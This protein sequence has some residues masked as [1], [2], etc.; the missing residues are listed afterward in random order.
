MKSLISL[1]LILSSFNTFAICMYPEDA[2]LYECLPMENASATKWCQA[3]YGEEFDAFLTNNTCSKKLAY[4]L[5]D[6]EYKETKRDKVG[7]VKAACLSFEQGQ[8]LNCEYYDYNLAQNFCGEKFGM[9][10][11]AF[12]PSSK[13]SLEVASKLRGEV[14]S[15]NLLNNLNSSVDELETLITMIDQEGAMASLENIGNKEVLIGNEFYTKTMTKILSYMKMTKDTLYKNS[16]KNVELKADKYVVSFLRQ[17]LKYTNLLSRI[18]KIY[19]HVAHKNSF[20]LK[21]YDFNNL[22]KLN[23]V[24]KKKFALELLAKVNFKVKHINNDQDLEFIVSDDERQSFEYMAV[25]QPKSKM[26]YAKLITFMGAREMLTNHWAVQ[27]LTS[28]E[29]EADQTRSC[30]QGFLS[31]RPEQNSM[32]RSSAYK[33]LWEY[34]LFFND[35]AVRWESIVKSSWDESII[36]TSTGRKMMR[37]IFSSNPSI[38]KQIKSS[39]EDTSIESELTSRSISDLEILKEAEDMAWMNFSN[40]HFSTIVFPG[41]DILH[42]SNVINKIVATAYAKRKESIVETFVAMYPYMKDREVNSLSKS[43]ENYLDKNLK[44]N[45][46]RRV[47]NA[48]FPSFEGYNSKEKRAS[49]REKKVAETLKV[50]KDAAAAVAVEIELS[51][52][53]PNLN[54][55][56]RVR[57]HNMKEL[58]TVFESGM[59][60]QLN[61]TLQNDKEKALLA[62]NFFKE[63]NSEFVRL[64]TKKDSKGNT[65]LSGKREEREEGLKNIV[66]SISA[67]Y[68]KKYPYYAANSSLLDERYIA[69]TRA[70]DNTYVRSSIYKNGNVIPMKQKTFEKEFNLKN[71]RFSKDVYVIKKDKTKV[72]LPKVLSGDYIKK[73]NVQSGYNSDKISTGEVVIYDTISKKDLTEL[74]RISVKGNKEKVLNQLKGTSAFGSKNDYQKIT[75]TLTNKIKKKLKSDTLKSTEEMFHEIF[76]SLGIVTKFTKKINLKYG[77]AQSDHAQLNLAGHYLASAYQAAPLLRSDVYWTETNKVKGTRRRHHARTAKSAPLAQRIVDVAYNAKTGAFDDSKALALINQVIDST[78]KNASKKLS[79]FCN[80]NYINYKN[81]VGFKQIFKASSFLR[82]N[83]KSP[84]GVSAENY[85]NIEKFDKEITKELRSYMEALNEDYLEPVLMW[86]GVVA[87]IALGVVF[88]IGTGG[89]GI[90]AMIVGFASLIG[91]ADMIISAPIIAA[92]LYARINTHFIEMPAQMKFNQSLAHSQLGE[93]S[94]IDWDMHRT[95]KKEMKTQQ[96]WQVGF[97]ALDVFF[98]GSLGQHVRRAS[99]V[100]AKNSYKKATGTVL[101]SWSAP[102]SS[103]YRKISFKKF[104]SKN[105]FFKSVQGKVTNVIDS[106]RLYQPK[107]QSI[108]VSQLKTTALRQGLIKEAAKL[109]ISKKPWSLLDNLQNY[110]AKLANRSKNYKA[111]LKGSE[112]LIEATYKS[113]FTISELMEHGRK[114]SSTIFAY[115]SFVKAVKEKRVREYLLKYGEEIK[116]LDKMRGQLIS[117]RQSSVQLAI[118]KLIDLKKA[119][120]GLKS[121][122]DEFGEFLSKL[123][124][125]EILALQQVANDGGWMK[126]LTTSKSKKTLMQ[127]LRPAF[128]NYENVATGFRNPVYMNGVRGVSIA[129]TKV[130]YPKSTI[131]GDSS[132]VVDDAYRF[133]SDSEDIV[134]FYESMIKQSDL[135]GELK[136]LASELESKISKRFKF[137]SNGKRVFID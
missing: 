11:I 67:K 68:F 84:V 108:P 127:K 49:N 112:E 90:P 48:I 104:R 14:S 6:E 79:E 83:L 28:I 135:R 31:L 70:I 115:K 12:V 64:F 9:K 33:S 137:D 69:A 36:T 39:L 75:K 80:A 71:Y 45:Y 117:Q 72:Y 32:I 100:I 59:S 74:R 38:I 7:Q 109:N 136:N 121:T 76:T 99:G 44:S 101:R 57:P 134:N 29:I 8:K 82:S 94:I 27:R 20:V 1:I 30:G 47:T 58:M 130:I 62:Q 120:A 81:D 124:D 2:E 23:L 5:R 110:S 113:K 133:N 102:S 21:S 122:G 88:C 77:L 3:K 53:E 15:H 86:S 65:V 116:L 123:T 52:D 85:S 55:V 106:V 91:T 87:M 42:K 125:D 37:S 132:I 66:H 60:P 26:E 13:C 93:S 4:S 41:D 10:Y 105:N 126:R 46:I 25:S 35:Y 89:A 97:M 56:K 54:A 43:V 50:I 34:D 129:T 22:S 18:Y 96:L 119:K 17:A 131:L 16:Q 73:Q 128:K 107:F 24:L 40:Y 103:L 92:S 61:S 118:D 98:V 114:Y 111:Y 63:I 78:I 95:A 51:K 19:A